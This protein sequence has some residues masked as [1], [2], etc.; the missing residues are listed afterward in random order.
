MIKVPSRRKIKYFQH[1]IQ[2]CSLCILF[3]KNAKHQQVCRRIGD[4]SRIATEFY[5]QA[6]VS[7]HTRL[8]IECRLII[9][10]SSGE[11][12]KVMN[13]PA[14]TYQLVIIS[15]IRFIS[16]WSGEYC[17]PQFVGGR[18][19]WH[20]FKRETESRCG[21]PKC[22]SKIMGICFLSLRVLGKFQAFPS[23][24]NQNVTRWLE[25]SRE[26]KRVI[27]DNDSIKWQS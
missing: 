22:W 26:S 12:W 8:E 2:T 25:L 24:M 17:H 11:K 4:A 19:K 20:P 13:W 7:T 6:V 5:W 1:P 21:T 15:S 23:W 14:F 18:V 16:S 27:V 3:L 10:K 9:F